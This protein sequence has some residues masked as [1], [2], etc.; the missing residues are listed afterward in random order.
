V[1]ALFR[2]SL[3]ANT[4]NSGATYKEFLRAR[5]RSKALEYLR[6]QRS[7]WQ[8]LTARRDSATRTDRG[9]VGQPNQQVENHGGSDLSAIVSRD[10]RQARFEHAKACDCPRLPT[11][12]SC[13][14]HV[15]PDLGRARPLT[16]ACAEYSL[17]PQLPPVPL[18]QSRLDTDTAVLAHAGG[19]TDEDEPPNELLSPESRRWKRIQNVHRFRD[20]QSLPVSDHAAPLDDPQEASSDFIHLPVTQPLGN[21]KLAGNPVLNTAELYAGIRRIDATTRAYNSTGN[22]KK[23]A[24]NMVSEHLKPTH[25]ESLV[26][27]QSRPNT[28]LGAGRADPFSTF[29]IKLDMMSQ[30][31]VD[32]F[33][34]AMPF[35]EF[36]IEEGALLNPNRHIAFYS[37]FSSPAAFHAIV[38]TGA[39]HLASL[40]TEKTS[41]VA[42]H[43]LIQSV[44]LLREALE[45]FD[46]N[47][48]PGIVQAM[49]ELAANEDFRG[50]HESS[51]LHLRGLRDFISLL[52]GITALELAP[53]VQLLS[54]YVCNSV[55]AS[56]LPRV[57]MRRTVYNR[58][59]NS[60]DVVFSQ[61]ADSASNLSGETRRNVG[62]IIEHV[63]QFRRFLSRI[64]EET[65]PVRNS[66]SVRRV[67]MNFFHPGSGLYDILSMSRAD[68]MHSGGLG[69]KGNHRMS[70]L[71]IISLRLLGFVENEQATMDYLG[72]LRMLFQ[73]YRLKDHPNPRLLHFVLLQDGAPSQSGDSGFLWK[74]VSFTQVYKLL[75]ARMKEHI[76]NIILSFL[77][78]CGTGP[79]SVTL[80]LKPLL[81]DVFSA[82]VCSAPAEGGE[83]PNQKWENR[84]ARRLFDPRGSSSSSN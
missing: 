75:S 5:A 78:S 83:G 55:S 19:N 3:A 76:N 15:V 69:P 22:S 43:H 72:K 11:P 4:S 33:I 71:L 53:R 17:R 44:R 24:L 68:N 34:H 20:Q 80:D 9:R 65:R 29:P 32:H 25:S 82:L 61:I 77:T 48:S 81:Q 54:C 26:Q 42:T 21:S 41:V 35:I 46:Q 84:A 47:T 38:A 58:S 18:L 8:P 56:Y 30:K 79:V 57:R 67:V 59:S 39:V 7:L 28:L 23:D 2:A 63:H 50:Q 36:N 74:V 64:I 52:G 14:Q 12:C 16:Q 27:R 70:C 66:L 73:K 49:A 51:K 31:C 45:A 37:V 13:S 6:S 10:Q 1:L 40:C 62:D 60:A